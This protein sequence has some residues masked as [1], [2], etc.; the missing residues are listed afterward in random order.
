MRE[1]YLK[2]KEEEAAEDSMRKEQEGPVVM[3]E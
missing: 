3:P 2:A 1:E